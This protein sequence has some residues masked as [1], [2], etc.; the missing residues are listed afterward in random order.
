M[1]ERLGGA[2]PGGT[3]GAA[4]EEPVIALAL[5][6]RQHHEAVVG[7]ADLAVAIAREQLLGARVI[8]V[9]EAGLHLE[10]VLGRDGVA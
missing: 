4:P 8:E 7:R 6:E 2:Q 5:I 3:D 9:L 10:R 1:P